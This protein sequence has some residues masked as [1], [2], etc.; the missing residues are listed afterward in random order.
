MLR[1]RKPLL[2]FAAV[3]GGGLLLSGCHFGPG[4][5]GAYRPHYNYGYSGYSPKSYSYGPRYRDHGYERRKYRGR[6]PYH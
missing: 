1:T 2:S 6:H 3:I 5:Q 4:Y